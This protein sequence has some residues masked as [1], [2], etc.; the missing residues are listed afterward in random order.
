MIKKIFVEKALTR[1]HIPVAKYTIN[2]Y[3]GCN[4]GCKY[5]FAKFIGPFKNYGKDWGKDVYVKSNILEILA[6]ELKKA[7]PSRVFLSTNCDPYQPLENKYGLT[8]NIINLLAKHGF[9]VSIFTKATLVKR[10]IDLLASSFGSE[11]T[12]SITSDIDKIT[13]I[14]EPGASTFEERLETLRVLKQNGINVNAFIGPVLP[15]NPERMANSLNEIVDRVHLDPLNY[16]WQ[17]RDIYKKNG[18]EAWLES[19][20]FQRVKGVFEKIF[21]KERII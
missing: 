8:R 7:K 21:G 4:I 3:I 19:S 20:T 5:C 6:V 14:F 11:V 10:D 9:C 17:V 1:T 18:L 13:R 15:M 16:S 2:P 12:L